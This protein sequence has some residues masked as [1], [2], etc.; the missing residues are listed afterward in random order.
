MKEFSLLP[1]LEKYLSLDEPFIL[2]CSTWADSM[3]LLYK[4]L[5]TPYRKNL[6]AAYFN[7]NTREQCRQEE[8]FLLELGKKEG[9]QLEIGECNFEKIKK[10]YTSKSFE[11]LAREKRYQFFDALCHIH[12][13]QKV[14]L[15]HHLDDR[16]ETMLFNMLRGTK[17]TWLINM[18]EASGILYRPLLQIQ[19]QDI[20]SYLHE[21]SLPYFEDESNTKNEFTRNYIRNEISPLLSQVHPEYKKNIWNLLGYFEDMKLF[22]DGK[23]DMFLWEKKEFWVKEFLTESEFLQKEIL[24]KMYFHANNNS[25]IGL[26][27]AN[28][29]EILRFF[30]EKKW[31]WIKEI[32]GLKMRKEKGKVYF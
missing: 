15:A 21:H 27:E 13:A 9:F 4:I 16:I 18:Q 17:L 5:E 32:H 2:A 10:L 23:I 30:Q 6:I 29:A 31:T 7:H 19:K 22:L 11:E 24:R 20:L 8:D 12:G 28:I 26:S 14:L 3:F 25:T 1:F